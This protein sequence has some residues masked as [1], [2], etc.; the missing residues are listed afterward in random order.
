MT[1]FDVSKIEFLLQ[2]IST[3]TL[4]VKMFVRDAVS[5][6]VHC[7]KLRQLDIPEELLSHLLRQYSISVRF[8]KAISSALSF[9]V[10]IQDDMLTR[11]LALKC[12]TELLPFSNLD[13]KYMC[14]MNALESAPEVK[15]EANRGLDVNSIISRRAFWDQDKYFILPEASKVFD[16]CWNSTESQGIMMYLRNQSMSINFC[17]R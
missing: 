5:I 6:F 14:I 9:K 3:E 11:S 17:S 7:L 1:E 15:D 12:A 16:F 8:L 13:A 2:R 4:T 10:F